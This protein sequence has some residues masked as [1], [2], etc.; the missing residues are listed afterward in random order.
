M[1]IVPTQ[2]AVSSPTALQTL[3]PIVRGIVASGR[4]AGDALGI[5]CRTRE[6]MPPAT[7]L[8]QSVWL[9]DSVAAKGR[10]EYVFPWTPAESLV[11]LLVLAET[12][13]STADVAEHFGGLTIA[14]GALAYFTVVW[15]PVAHPTANIFVLGVAPPHHE[16]TIHPERE[17]LFLVVIA[18]VR[19]LCGNRAHRGAGNVWGLAVVATV[20]VRIQ[21]Y[22]VAR[23]VHSHG[24]CAEEALVLVRTIYLRV[25][26]ANV[27]H[28]AHLIHPPAYHAVGVG[29]GALTLWEALIPKGLPAVVVAV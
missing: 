27:L 14:E 18:Q 22:F 21:V 2:I 20:D 8:H 7:T 6:V 3:S 24:F 10:R 26:V 16:V 19:S 17:T 15:I 25:T 11:R 9:S 4:V 23:T 13:Q 28:V 12:V 29:G 1:H 5:L